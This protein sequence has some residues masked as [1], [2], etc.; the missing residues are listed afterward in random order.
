MATSS[1]FSNEPTER[2]QHPVE[3]PLEKSEL[4]AISHIGSNQQISTFGIADH[5]TRAA[6][7]GNKSRRN[8]NDLR[9]D[10]QQQ[11][12]CCRDPDLCTP[13]GRFGKLEQ[14]DDREG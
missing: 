12:S 10:D 3:A 13:L 4:V 7:S 5:V 1:D 9:S 6:N 2:F 14:A 8:W 11:G